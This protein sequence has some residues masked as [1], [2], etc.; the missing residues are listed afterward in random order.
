MDSNLENNIQIQTE[1]K[2]PY[3]S[4]GL[5]IGAVIISIIIGFAFALLV[6]KDYVGINMF[7]FSLMAILGVGYML[8]KD[9]NLDVKN[10]A[11]FGGAFLIYASVFFRLEQEVYTVLAFPTLLALLIV[12]TMFSS[13]KTAKL[14]I[15]TFLYRMFG[16]IARVDKIFVGLSSLKQGDK[17]KKQKSLQ[18]LWG[19][20]ISAGLLI[21][22]IPLM[23]SAEAAFESFIENIVENI[24]LNFD[25]QKFFWK[26]VAGIAIAVIF[27]GFLWTFTKD[28]M[29]GSKDKKKIADGKDNHAM[30]IT[31]LSVMGLVFLLFSIIQFNSLFVSKESIIEN[32]TFAEAARDGY[33][34]LVV[35]SIINFVMVLFCTGM[36]CGSN[37][38][39]RNI[40][41][42]L[43]TYFTVLNVY[44][45]ASSAYKMTL[46]YDAYGLSVERLLVYILLAYELLALAL[47]VVK[48]YKSDMKFIKTMIYYTVAFWAIASFINIESWVAKVNIN[49]YEKT[50]EIDMYY[51]TRLGDDASGEIKQF[52]FD[53]YEELCDEGQKRIDYYYFDSD[54]YWLTDDPYISYDLYIIEEYEEAKQLDSWLEFSFSKVSKNK[55]GLEIL[56]HY[57]ETGYIDEVDKSKR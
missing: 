30:I 27:G 31:V 28:K 21:I 5:D 13:K 12:T 9:D 32:S 56:H 22:V 38:V 46:Y 45:L 34:Q 3:G 19:V 11:F 42:G 14:G 16:P 18:V 4:R 20:L 44:L 40:I 1:E 41:K 24:E 54:K 52:Y 48:I 17:P 26:T 37:K 25:V 7:L 57:Y 2:S 50:G 39:T 53:N 29:N 49:R 47:L 10:F 43:T 35:L 23:M 8:H 51:L 36:E 6:I 55:D 15:A 33:F